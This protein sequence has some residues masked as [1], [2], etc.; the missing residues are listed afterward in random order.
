VQ[1]PLEWSNAQAY[2]ETR[3]EAKRVRQM[4]RNL[5]EIQ[6]DVTTDGLVESPRQEKFVPFVKERTSLGKL[7]TLSNAPGPSKPKGGFKSERR[8]ES[9]MQEVAYLHD[10]STAADLA[11]QESAR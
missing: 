11:R 4:K 3:A 8:L 9:T 5:S 7:I 6:T 10:E 2:A 1:L